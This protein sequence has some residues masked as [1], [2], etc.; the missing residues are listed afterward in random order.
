MP[1]NWFKPPLF[2]KNAWKSQH[3]DCNHRGV[4]GTSSQHHALLTEFPD[5]WSPCGAHNRLEGRGG[6]STS[7]DSYALDL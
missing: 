7:K 1:L 3:Q 2:L 4:Q 6:F 5:H